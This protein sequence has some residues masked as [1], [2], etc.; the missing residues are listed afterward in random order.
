MIVEPVE[1]SLRA[2]RYRWAELLRRIFEVDPL[3]CPWCRGLMRIVAV[4][5]DPA[6]ITRILAHRARVRD[7]PHRSRSPPPRRRRSP[8][9]TAAGLPHP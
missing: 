8:T 2:A 4:I 9:P 6:V 3:A 1:W 7:S 5:T